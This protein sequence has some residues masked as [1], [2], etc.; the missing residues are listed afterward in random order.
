MSDAL[1]TAI[2]LAAALG[3]I[4][5]VV[6]VLWYRSKR[7]GTTLKARF[8]QA[9]HTVFGYFE[10]SGT[11]G[12]YPQRLTLFSINPPGPSQNVLTV[13]FR[14]HGFY[15]GRERWIFDEAYR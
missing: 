9:T 3:A 5:L 12:R 14:R 4:H 15:F 8:E 13:T 10:V 6:G 11:A 2:V 1:T 7:K